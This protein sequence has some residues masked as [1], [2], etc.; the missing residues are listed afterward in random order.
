[1]KVKPLILLKIDFSESTVFMLWCERR[2]SYNRMYKQFGLNMR[3]KWEQKLFCVQPEIATNLSTG[4][5]PINL[6]DFTLCNP[7][8]Q[9]VVANA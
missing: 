5:P 1:M 2:D 4:N 6:F 9:G 8:L 7:L 3:A